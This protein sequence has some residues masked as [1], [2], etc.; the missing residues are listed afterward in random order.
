LFAGPL[1]FERQLSIKKSESFNYHG[2]FTPDKAHDGKYNTWYQPKD[3]HVMGNYLKLYLDKSQSI[4]KV[5]VTSIQYRSRLKNTEVVVY[6]TEGVETAVFN[7]GKITG[8]IYD[9]RRKKFY[10]NTKIS[11]KNEKIPGKLFSLFN[12]SQKITISETDST[13]T[14]TLHCNGAVGDMVYLTDLDIYSCCGHHIY[15]VRIYT[16][17]G[18]GTD[19]I[20]YAH[21]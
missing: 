16:Y 7:C 2:S 13:K 1:A 6:S 18:R 4:S 9:K 12:F 8:K 21:A 5:L 3:K 11:N 15:E 19:E 10:K 20:F 14:Y 17:N